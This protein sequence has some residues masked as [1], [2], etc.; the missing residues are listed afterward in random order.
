MPIDKAD[1]T[2]LFIRLEVEE[3]LSLYVM[4]ARDGTIHRLGR[5]TI[6]NDQ[7]EMYTGKTS[8]QLFESFIYE[9]DVSMLQY[10]GV[11]EDSDAEGRACKL[12]MS[13]QMGDEEESVG[14]EFRYGS[15]SQGPPVEICDLVVS[16]IDLTEPW[17]EHQIE[18]TSQA[19]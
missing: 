14:F 5:G 10:A 16:C 3:E 2:A 15:D 12:T 6:D 18:M 19:H 4:L 1:I 11:Y 8:D 13:F 7:H 17:F 9:F